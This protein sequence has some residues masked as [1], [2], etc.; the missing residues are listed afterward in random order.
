MLQ[1][2]R[3]RLQIFGKPVEDIAKALQAVAWLTGAGHLVILIRE[4]HEED[5]LAL[6][7]Q[8]RKKLFGLLYPT[9]QIVFSV[10]DEQRCRDILA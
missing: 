6:P 5:L 9:A 4:A 7:F 2:L 10:Q 8:C 3:R 1:L